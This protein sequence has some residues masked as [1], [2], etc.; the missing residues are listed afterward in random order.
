MKNGISLSQLQYIED[1]VRNF[2][3]H[4]E[5]QLYTPMEPHSTP[6]KLLVSEDEKFDPRLYRH[7]IGSLMHLET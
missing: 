7:L 5:N 3:S 6:R 4:K 1:M 2:S